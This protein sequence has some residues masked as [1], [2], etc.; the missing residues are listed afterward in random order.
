M[1]QTKENEKDTKNNTNTINESNISKNEIKSEDLHEKKE[2]NN[3]SPSSSNALPCEN[4]LK[5]NIEN[6]ENEIIFDKYNFLK[7][8][9]ISD[10]TKDFL[11]SNTSTVRPEL[12]EYTK[13]YLNSITDTNTSTRPELTKLTKEYLLQNE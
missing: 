5:L 12:N 1:D 10:I 6:K 3:S 11:M 2:N 7:N 13:A 9:E 8:T 4:N